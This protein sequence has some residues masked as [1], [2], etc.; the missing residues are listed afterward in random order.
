MILSDPLAH[1]TDYHTLAIY[2]THAF[3]ML[4]GLNKK[5]QHEVK[6]SIMLEG[7]DKVNAWP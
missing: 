5:H 1:Q 4:K 7:T 3:H 2:L 6:Q